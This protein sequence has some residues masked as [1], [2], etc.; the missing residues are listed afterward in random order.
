MDPENEDKLQIAMEELTKN[1]TVIIIAHRLKTIKNAD[2]ILVLDNG[3][4]VQRGTHEELI[5]IDGIYK[6]FV[7]ARQMAVG[8][9]LS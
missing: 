8:W 2:Q 1:K 7:E 6:N 3:K 5:K 4:I 9:I